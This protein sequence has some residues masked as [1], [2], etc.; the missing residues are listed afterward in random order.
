MVLDLG[1][2]TTEFLCPLSANTFG[3]EFLSFTIGAFQRRRR[4]P[5]LPRAPLAPPVDELQRAIGR[6]RGGILAA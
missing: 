5:S 6:R 4:A 3:I 1:K 2:P